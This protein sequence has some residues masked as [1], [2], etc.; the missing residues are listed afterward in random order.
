MDKSS[1]VEVT[2]ANFAEV[3]LQSSKPVVLAVGAPW[4]KDCVRAAPFYFA[5]SQELG[6][7]LT[8]AA[9]NSD[10]N[11]N[12]KA[13]L[14]VQHIPTMIIFKNGIANDERL[15]EVKT[16]S[17]LKNFLLRGLEG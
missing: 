13:S 12:L 7:R 15:V 2:E 3:V 1:L 8:F 17:E 4:C 16:P 6:D 9:C 11:P 14:G 5:L 10:D